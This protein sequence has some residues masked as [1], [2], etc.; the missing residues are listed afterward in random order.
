MFNWKKSARNFTFFGVVNTILTMLI[1]QLFVTF[2]SPTVS[3]SISWIIGLL[4]VV[5]LYPHH[6]FGRAG[7]SATASLMVAI[8][9]FVFIVGLSITQFCVYLNVGERYIVFISIIFCSAISFFLSRWALH[10]LPDRK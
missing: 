4:F 6:V 5:I 7:S 2:L 10:R 1:Y 8:Y 9:L 3:Y